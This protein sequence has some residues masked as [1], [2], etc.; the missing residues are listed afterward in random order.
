MAEWKKFI[1]G[2]EQLNEIASS[3]HGF[4]TRFTDGRSS[5]PVIYRSI[6]EIEDSIVNI[7]EYLI[8][9]P[10]RHAEK[11]K[12]WADTGQPV[13]ERPSPNKEWVLVNDPAWN[14]LWEYTF[15]VP[16]K[17]IEVRDYLYK[18]GG[19]EYWKGSVHKS[20]LPKQETLV[21]NVEA[22]EG[23]IRWLDDDW[24]EIEI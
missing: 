18:A 15:D 8:C 20:Q 11:I 9:E 22:M 4:L 5:W 17:F 14:P 7:A 2:K 23:F 3:K 6:S 13:Y 21:K 19:D 12:R 16:R 24:N 1:F 10:H